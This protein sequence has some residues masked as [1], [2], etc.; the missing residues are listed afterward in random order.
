MSGFKVGKN[1][2]KFQ[3]DM[4]VGKDKRKLVELKPQMT[5][6]DFTNFLILA[7]IQY[8]MRF[9]AEMLRFDKNLFI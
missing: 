7:E 5:S 1:K 6:C 4:A 8:K 9:L 2:I 3:Y